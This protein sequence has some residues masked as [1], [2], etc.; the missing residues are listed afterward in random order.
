MIKTHKMPIIC[1]I[2]RVV[3]GCSPSV[4]F[5]RCSAGLKKKIPKCDGCE[6]NMQ[7]VAFEAFHR[8]LESGLNQLAESEEW[9]IVKKKLEGLK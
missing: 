9:K 6:R 7:S 3:I 2:R 4:I 8:G 1:K 5:G